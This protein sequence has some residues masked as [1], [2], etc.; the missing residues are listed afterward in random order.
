V[1]D[2]VAYV[3]LGAGLGFGA[4]IQPG[5]FQAFLLSRTIAAGWRRTLPICFAPLLSDGPIAA[6]AL[7]VVGQVPPAAQHALRACGGL[8]LLY[9]AIN[10][11]RH[12]GQP[13]SG[14]AGKA[15]PRSIVEAAFINLLNPNPYIAWALVMGPAVVSAWHHHRGYAAA[16]L[17][18]FYATMFTA[19]AGIVLLAG[20]ARYLDA[21]NQRR[22]AVASALLLGGLGIVLL[23]MGV[24]GLAGAGTGPALGVSSLP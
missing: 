6:L 3:V 2:L 16:F 5:P 12:A 13:V 24:R 8:L 10:A 9:L 4:S 7:L 11:V 1:R 15:T 22:L 23:V 18:V 19:N 14:A 21:R 17:A 20:T